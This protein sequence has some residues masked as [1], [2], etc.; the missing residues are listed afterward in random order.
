M[1]EIRLNVTP[2]AIKYILRRYKNKINMFY[3]KNNNLL[4]YFK[5]FI[6][7]KNT[8]P[9]FIYIEPT[10]ICNAKCIYCAYQFYDAKKGNMTIETLDKVLKESKSIG[11]DSINLTPFAGEILVDKNIMDKIKLIKDYKF[12]RVITYTNLLSL[13]KINIKEFLS[14]GLTELHISSGPLE[15]DL[16]EKIFHVKKYNRFLD[17]LKTLLKEFNVT[18]AKIIK[19]IFIEFRSPLS[20]NECINLP[21][22][23]KH[24]KELISK[25]IHVS[26]MSTFDS[27]MGI[28]KE[29]DLIDGMKIKKKMA[30][31]FLLVVG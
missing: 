3:T 8:S 13:H 5:Q 25:N 23:K 1:L 9:V 7:K 18:N 28:I 30:K 21:D 4:I 17:N 2:L 19:K 31:N 10:N 14:S 20:F 27:W 16:Y 11:I 22:Y 26:S 15:K 24:I 6:L 12:N 29:T